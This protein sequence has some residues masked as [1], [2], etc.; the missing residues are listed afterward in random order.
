MVQR[1]FRK[2]LEKTFI[3]SGNQKLRTNETSSYNT[4]PGFKT[5]FKLSIKVL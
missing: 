4:E 1:K 2:D 5:G 3:W